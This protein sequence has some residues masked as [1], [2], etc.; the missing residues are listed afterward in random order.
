MAFGTS[1]AISSVL[2]QENKTDE[3]QNFSD[4]DDDVLAQ[5]VERALEEAK[6][7]SDEFYIDYFTNFELNKNKKEFE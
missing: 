6:I 5:F 3:I 7:V 4:L 2:S 1:I